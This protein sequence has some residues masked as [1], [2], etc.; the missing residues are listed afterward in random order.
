MS[1]V[2]SQNSSSMIARYFTRK[3]CRKCSVKISD[4]TSENS[5]ICTCLLHSLDY[6]LI[7]SVSQ[8]VDIA[9][10]F[11]HTSGHNNCQFLGSRHGKNTSTEFRRSVPDFCSRKLK[12]GTCVN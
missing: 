11:Q 7:Y 5:R 8:N 12:T 6:N 4:G 2:N 3:I 10:T 1:L 9:Q